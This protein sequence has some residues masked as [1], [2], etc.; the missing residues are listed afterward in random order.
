MPLFH[1]DI[2]I[3]DWVELPTH[4]VRLAHSGHAKQQAEARGL[5]L[6][7]YIDCGASAPFEVEATR[8]GRVLKL[9]YR[10]PHDE[11]RDICVVVAVEAAGPWVVKTCWAN[12]RDDHHSTL[13]RERYATC[14]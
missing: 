11:W 14:D 9:A 10:L 4:V 13:N 3:P 6:P 7:K 12:D 8:S 2:G 1:A 5:W